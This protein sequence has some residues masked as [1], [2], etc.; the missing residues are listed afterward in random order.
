MQ[1]IDFLIII[2]YVVGCTAFGAYLGSG[3]KELK[4]YFLG[5]SNIP[6]WAVMI[7]I[8]ATETSTATFLSVPGIAYGGDLTY[9][10]L[11]L[12]YLVGRVLVAVFLLP[13]YF[14]A[15]SSRLIRFSRTGSAGRPGRRR[16]SCS[17]RRG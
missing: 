11:P 6:A 3:T 8:V 7:S 17:S 9:L 14:R 4:G 2:F 16:R 10:Q 13:S 1:A 15:K 5:E 12:G